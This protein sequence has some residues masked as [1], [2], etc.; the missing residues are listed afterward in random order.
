MKINFN[1]LWKKDLG[2]IYKEVS[3]DG[4]KQFKVDI[5]LK[6]VKNIYANYKVNNKHFTDS[7]EIVDIENNIINIPFRSSVLEKGKHELEIKAVMKNGNVLPSNTFN[8]LV[9]TFIKLIYLR[10]QI[11]TSIFIYY[12]SSQAI[13]IFI[14]FIS[15]KVSRILKNLNQI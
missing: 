10:L 3:I 14:I 1:Q 9:N 7:I 6:E 2:L 11:S 12:Y 5:D 8:Y 13:I 4:G 15:F